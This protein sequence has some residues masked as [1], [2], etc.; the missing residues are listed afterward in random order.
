MRAS[1]YFLYIWGNTDCVQN[2][3]IWI[4]EQNRAPNTCAILSF[5]PDFLTSDICI[6][7]TNSPQ[8]QYR[9][10][11]TCRFRSTTY[12]AFGR[13]FIS[14]EWSRINLFSLLGGTIIIEN[15]NWS[16]TT[17][18]QVPMTYRNTCIWP[19]PKCWRADGDQRQDLNPTRHR[20]E[21][22]E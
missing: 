1:Q 13:F 10:C 3:S 6:W 18:Q 8:P 22:K 5:P 14:T 19:Q 15:W 4:A 12:F 20:R 17:Y 7:P 11:Q 9:S 16:K 21:D 2:R